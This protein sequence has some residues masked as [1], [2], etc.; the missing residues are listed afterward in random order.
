M[1]SN[2]SH[3]FLFCLYKILFCLT[4]DIYGSN[5]N[6]H[7]R[8]S[9]PQLSTQSLDDINKTLLN[10]LTIEAVIQK[11]K[12][13]QYI[14]ENSFIAN[15]F[16]YKIEDNTDLQIKIKQY[17]QKN[18]LENDIKTFF[19]INFPDI[20]SLNITQSIQKYEEKKT[21]NTT[22][23][24]TQVEEIQNLIDDLNNN[25]NF[26]YSDLNKY[27]ESFLESTNILLDKKNLNNIN[28]QFR[29]IQQIQGINRQ[30]SYKD[31]TTQEEL[32]TLSNMITQ[33]D[34]IEKKLS[35]Q[36]ISQKQK[37]QDEPDDMFIYSNINTLEGYWKQL[38]EI[39]NTHQ[40]NQQLFTIHQIIKYDRFFE[41]IQEN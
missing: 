11:I 6:P 30:L 28:N 29:N 24:K 1:K 10:K 34:D 7:L 25:N 27:I 35:Q 22:T 32:Q 31:I 13:N 40:K 19:K 33:F 15:N 3:I 21:E 36:L 20:K 23:I 5:Q 18:Q 4:Y 12:N 16:I 37:L 26:S 8:N 39:L 9:S 2:K 17:N 41:E 38:D 14:N